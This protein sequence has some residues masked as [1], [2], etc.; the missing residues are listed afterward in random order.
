MKKSLLLLAAT[1]LLTGCQSSLSQDFHH[2]TTTPKSQLA[3][4]LK[5]NAASAIDKLESA[6]ENDLRSRG[7]HDE[8]K[9]TKD[10]VGK[11]VE[12]GKEFAGKVLN[13]AGK[14]E[15][16]N[17]LL[18]LHWTNGDP[19]VIELPATAN[20]LVWEDFDRPHVSYSNLDHYNRAGKATAKLTKEN[21]VKESKR[22]AQ[23]WKPTGFQNQKKTVNGKKIYPLARGHLIAYSLTANLNDDGLYAPGH[24]GSLDNPK[25]LFSQ[26]QYTNSGVMQTYEEKV[27]KTLKSGKSV[28]YEVTPIFGLNDL[29]AKGVH[30]EAVTE[31]GTLFNV[32]IFNVTPGLTYDYLTGKSTVD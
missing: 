24:D 3:S 10:G 1:F 2:V 14:D 32:Y 17:Q 26:T 20:S 9:D 15:L 13:E 12:Q 31:D 7:L 16:K 18:S 19:E 22:E 21:V 11:T 29:M 30:L 25:N 8:I 5:E 23:T 6:L 4:E 27:R 28:I